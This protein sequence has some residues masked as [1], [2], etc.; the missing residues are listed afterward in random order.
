MRQTKRPG[1]GAG[2]EAITAAETRSGATWPTELREPFS[3]VNG[4]SADSWFPL[5]PSHDLFDLEQVIDEREVELELWSQFSNDA[6]QSDSNAGE[7]ADT[8]LPEFI[9]CAGID[10]NFSLS[11]LDQGPCRAV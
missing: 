10:G 11:M 6:E 4:I 7:P 3:H 8:W 1:A 5:F 9:P 2:P